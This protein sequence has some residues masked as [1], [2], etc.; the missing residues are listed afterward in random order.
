MYNSSFIP[1][2]DDSR[3]TG[4]N[5]LEKVRRV[6]RRGLIEV[7]RRPYQHSQRV[8]S[9][10]TCQTRAAYEKMRAAKRSNAVLYRIKSAVREEMA[11]RINDESEKIERFAQANPF[12]KMDGRFARAFER[13]VGERVYDRREETPYGGVPS[14][15]ACGA[16]DAKCGCMPNWGV[17]ATSP[18]PIVR[19]YSPRCAACLSKYGDDCACVIEFEFEP[20]VQTTTHSPTW[21]SYL[22]RRVRDVISSMTR[23]VSRVLN[24]V[25]E[26]VTLRSFVR[27]AHLEKMVEYYQ[28]LKDECVEMR[29]GMHGYEDEYD[30]WDALC[31]NIFDEDRVRLPNPECI[32]VG[33]MERDT[34]HGSE[35]VKVENKSN[36]T[37]TTKNE[38]TPAKP[39]YK[40]IDWD[41]Y[42]TSDKIVR[43]KDLTERWFTIKQGYWSTS[44]G[45]DYELFYSALPCDMFDK[46]GGV[47]KCK[48]MLPSAAPF[49]VHSQFASDVEVMLLLNANAHQ[50]GMCQLSWIYMD[51]VQDNTIE[52]M[53]ANVF[54]LSSTHHVLISASSQ[55][56]ARLYIPYVY[57][58]PMMSLRA[59]AGYDN[60]RTMGTLRCR[61][62][63]K[64]TI[65]SGGPNKCYYTLKARFVNARFSGMTVLNLDA[66]M[67]PIGSMVMEMAMRRLERALDEATFSGDNPTNP[68]PPPYIV[69]RAA[70]NMSYGN[71]V[72]EPIMSMRLNPISA[73]ALGKDVCKFDELQL[74]YLTRV[75]GL[76]KSYQWK[77]SFPAGYSFEPEGIAV[78]PMFGLMMNVIK[79]LDKKNSL[80]GDSYCLPPVSVMSALYNHF[81]GSFELRTDFVASHFH[82]GK[83]M[84][85]YVPGLSEKKKISM[86]VA[87]G[88]PHIIIDI[89]AQNSVTF[90]VP[91]ISPSL[92]Q[93]RSYTGNVE[94][95]A[96]QQCSRVYIFVLNPM[97]ADSA[98]S[99]TAYINLYAR[100]APDFELSVP[101]QPSI[102]LSVV[103]EFVPVAEVV[104][105]KGDPY[106][107]GQ[108]VNFVEHRCVLRYEYISITEPGVSEWP[109]PLDYQEGYAKYL[110]CE[111]DSLAPVWCNNETTPVWSEVT[112]IRYLV[113]T[114]VSSPRAD[115]WY[116]IPFV[117]EAF[118][119]YVYTS[120]NKY[121]TDLKTLSVYLL[122]D[123]NVSEKDVPYSKPGCKW[124]WK[125]IRVAMD[126]DFTFVQNSERDVG[127][128]I[129]GTT[130]TLTSTG[131][132]YQTYG[133]NFQN[134][135][136]LLRRYQLYGCVNIDLGSFRSA[137]E[138]RMSV[139]LCPQG[140]LLQVKNA[141]GGTNPT[142]NRGREGSIALVLSGFVGFTGGMN[143]KIVLPQID[144]CV[145]WVQ[146][147]P[148]AA[149]H[150]RTIKVCNRVVNGSDVLN[151]GFATEVQVCS[152]N[153]VIELNIPYYLMS[154][155]GLLHLV[156]NSAPDVYK[157]ICG[158]GTLNIGFNCVKNKNTSMNVDIMVFYAVADDFEPVIFYGFPPMVVLDNFP[159]Q[160][161]PQNNGV[162]C[163]RRVLLEPQWSPSDWLTK[164][165]NSVVQQSVN[166]N[167]PAA[168]NSLSEVVHQAFQ[169]K[170]E[171]LSKYVGVTHM[172][173]IASQVLHCV[174]NPDVKTFVLAIVTVFA[175]VGVIVYDKIGEWIEI[176]SN[177]LKK[178][179]SSYGGAQPQTN[180]P[181]GLV[182]QNKPEEDP[183]KEIVSWVTLIFTT[184]ATIF[185]CKSKPRSDSWVKCVD[186]FVDS[187]SASCRNGS[188]IY[189][190]MLKTFD[191]L[192]WCVCRVLRMVNVPFSMYELQK[193]CDVELKEWMSE[194]VR[195]TDKLV[196][197]TQKSVVAYQE[198]V[199]A[200]HSM[201]Q[202]LIAGMTPE[203][204][205]HENIQPFL[206]LYDKVSK[207][208]D[209][210]I[211]MGHSPSVRKEAFVLYVSGAAGIGKSSMVT[212]ICHDLLQSV[213]FKSMY[214]L[215]YVHNS[216]SE[217]WDQCMH[218]PCMVIDDM[219]N[220]QTPDVLS[221]QLLMLFAVCTNV[222]LCPPKAVAEDKGMRYNPE[223]VVFNSNHKYVYLPNCE[224]DAVNRRR[225]V[226]VEVRMRDM[227]KF[228]KMKVP[229][230]VHCETGNVCDGVVDFLNDMHHLEF[231]MCMNKLKEEPM[232]ETGW[233]D[234]ATFMVSCIVVFKRKRLASNKKFLS[235]CVMMNAFRVDV[236]N[237]LSEH[238][239]VNLECFVAEDHTVEERVQ[240]IRDV[241]AA[242]MLKDAGRWELL[243]KQVRTALTLG[244]E[245]AFHRAVYYWDEAYKQS[246]FLSE[247]AY[248]VVYACAKKIRDGVVNISS[249]SVFD[250]KPQVDF[251]EMH[252][253]DNI[254]V[255]DTPCFVDEDLGG[256][257]NG[258]LVNKVNA[259][260]E[261]M[262]QLN[263]ITDDM[264]VYMLR[265]VDVSEDL[266]DCYVL[267]MLEVYA[268]K[269][270]CATYVSW[271]NVM[272]DLVYNLRVHR[273]G[274]VCRHF[275]V[276]WEKIVCVN[277]KLIGIHDIT[278]ACDDEECC[279]RSVFFKYIWFACWLRKNPR[280]E[281]FR[282]QK[283]MLCL[284]VYLAHADVDELL[285]A[286]KKWQ[287]W[288]SSIWIDRIVPAARSVVAFLASNGLTILKTLLVVCTSVSL[289][290]LCVQDVTG[291]VTG[292]PS[293]GQPQR[294]N[295]FG[296]GKPY[297][298]G[299]LPKTRARASTNAT[300]SQGVCQQLDVCIGLVKR[301]SVMIECLYDGKWHEMRCLGLRN[302]RMLAIR[303]YMDNILAWRE[304]S[305]SEGMKFELRLRYCV[306]HEKRCGDIDGVPFDLDACKII[307]TSCDEGEMHTTHLCVIDLPRSRLPQFKN[308]EKF[309]ARE[310]DHCKTS[311]D[312][313][314]VIAESMV[315][316]CPFVFIDESEHVD[317]L[318]VSHVESKQRVEAVKLR[319]AY[320]YGVQRNGYCGSILLDGSLQRPIIGVHVA[321]SPIVNKGY[322]ECLFQED[323]MNVPRHAFDECEYVDCD[324][325]E[326]TEDML[327]AY[328]TTLMPQGVV[329][330]SRR[331]F[332][333]RATSIRPSAVH[334]VVPVRTEPNPLS[335]RDGRL[336]LPLDPLI[337]GVKHHGELVKDF[338][339]SLL[340]R[341]YAGVSMFVCKNAPNVLPRVEKL[342]M[343]EAV[344]GV[345]G[346]NELIAMT[347]NTSA[348]YPLQWEKPA[349]SGGKKWLFDLKESA[350]GYVLCGM[351]E[352]LENMLAVEMDMRKRGEC[353]YTIFVDCL[354]DTCLPLEK[355]RMNGK[356]RIFSISPVQYTIAFRQ[357]MA[358]FMVSYRRAR[359]DVG[360]GIGVNVNGPEWGML[361]C[362]LRMKGNN[363]CVGDYKNFGPGMNE[364]VARYAC[365]IMCDWYDVYFPNSENAV[366]RRCLLNELLNAPHLC[367]SLVYRVIAGVP[368][369]SPV[370]DILNSIVNWIYL[371]CAWYDI[372]NESFES[373]VNSVYVC[374]YGDDVIMS[375]HDRVKDKFNSVVLCEWFKKYDIIYTD[376]DKLGKVAAYRPLCEATFLKRGFVPHFLRVNE[377]LA[378]LEQI[379]VESPINWVHKG[380]P[381]SEAT[382]ANCL[383]ALELAYGRGPE[384]YNRISKIL[385]RALS[386]NRLSATLPSWEDVDERVFSQTL[387][388]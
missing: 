35:G 29:E 10:S 250:A 332:Q 133:E 46:M 371:T 211:Q 344:C 320:K 14:C 374:V 24:P 185:K 263:V 162:E 252:E 167:I 217:F 108:W 376:V 153:P 75:F 301:N 69:P 77:T 347:F 293:R 129:M 192:Q 378:P 164:R 325:G 315:V 7:L 183:R 78:E 143:V 333:V 40:P 363:I 205:A 4:F 107:A 276:D 220:V 360:H 230:C 237:D 384:E 34:A 329:P 234:Y 354:K 126:E 169:M 104:P 70:H 209:S 17:C 265:R 32:I 98:S 121:K 71:G 57:V 155:L 15:R 240:F 55:N 342:S 161:E 156:G 127:V 297:S 270:K 50:S 302:H 242:R 5:L 355:C 321:G 189:T 307:M 13:V 233:M 289:V 176:V 100:G 228:E 178:I 130:S 44:H 351:H 163:V 52:N 346:V 377:W 184:V 257:S 33:G 85:A 224:S 109:V 279:F 256:P 59:S 300:Y 21:V 37:V 292:K 175:N 309:I 306:D 338:P 30:R 6:S 312:G 154:V 8:M 326:V 197:D 375:V 122:N 340:H 195:V 92:W 174:M 273:P 359:F 258:M 372:M 79:N 356:T 39:E 131:Y 47:D 182:E 49:M 180:Q 36:V 308:L 316:S 259:S 125:T 370:T 318:V 191:V 245:A 148:D 361:A 350:D 139:P 385:V 73:N 324:L 16:W 285:V 304:R 147:R 328:S 214:E 132:G 113:V 20:S 51:H 295:A 210:L 142:F 25:V 291:A 171:K 311:G 298:A 158:L 188:Q 271:M 199:Y 365:I 151:H 61:V 269:R 367:E 341:A 327:K 254:C 266:V 284:P 31:A 261:R 173:N 369:G 219:W 231:K 41:T 381:V 352:K 343:Q 135:K 194:C 358:A 235:D 65:A 223:I 386:E 181:P 264:R 114:N 63:N 124:V 362:K 27:R 201:G 54:S 364:Q 203:M 145:V 330:S 53:R 255:S 120:I 288:L 97:I 196:F 88:C 123:T 262:V 310:A 11:R 190:F 144:G 319:Q 81:R 91:Y 141:Q 72:S 249:P 282:R 118:C 239:K 216:Q 101:V 280:M 116:A 157:F 353:P 349:G 84:I 76:L 198:R 64:L 248:K 213:N 215:I 366:V 251:E 67:F 149:C 28:I 2:F 226:L 106:Y 43:A 105:L 275:S 268:V 1:S 202:G 253:G 283:K 274:N 323:F 193:M 134:V 9:G 212:K 243:K 187:M 82:T 218:Q 331:H 137:Y 95:L 221:K 380:I 83:A 42:V 99:D 150:D 66:Q 322:S 267:D 23:N 18:S 111:N 207:V 166:E 165:M 246:A 68:L 140:L 58:F 345:P 159:E 87:E 200:V 387:S 60:S 204:V 247:Q 3:L 19:T 236:D 272:F 179:V 138:C 110:V 368:S 12:G 86:E 314:F 48:N 96:M 241:H 160:L 128:N 299:T 146:H 286:W 117:N 373:F 294:N 337:E 383:Q 336:P 303:H 119:Q 89:V 281:L 115:L 305:V 348:G 170:N 335:A 152:V 102:G 222:V 334:G 22:K 177:V 225:D 74:K 206:R 317:G 38:I 379:S 277:R 260:L 93:R 238:L 382:V 208:Y 103:K 357:Y 287:I 232:S 172:M 186:M 388:L 62:L 168:M 227:S 26:G 45:I 278:D 229:G 90:R 313:M 136:D 290:A 80:V 94:Q 339:L 112:P 244:N 296:Q 56:E